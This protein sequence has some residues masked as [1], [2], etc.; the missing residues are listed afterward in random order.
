MLIV[1]SKHFFSD[2]LDQVYMF[3]P[4]R[5]ARISERGVRR[6]LIR[7]EGGD[8]EFAVDIAEA[9]HTALERDG[10]PCS[11]FLRPRSRFC[12]RITAVFDNHT[13]HFADVVL[14]GELPAE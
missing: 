3:S 6:R 10:C 1:H 8:P 12:R 14:D 7:A 9:A 11:V 4:G 5:S 2:L 13:G